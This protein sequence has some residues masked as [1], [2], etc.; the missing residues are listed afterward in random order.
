MVTKMK[1][2]LVG[3]WLRSESVIQD[4]KKYDHDDEDHND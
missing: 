1:A 2:L 3:V 4:A